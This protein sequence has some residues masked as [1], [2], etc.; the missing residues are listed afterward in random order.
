MTKTI[1]S[2][3][4]AGSALAL[5]LA[6]PALA[7]DAP[8]VPAADTQIP[9]EQAVVAGPALWKVADEDTTI[10]L[11]GTVHALPEGTVWFTGPVEDALESSDVLVTEI[12][13]TPDAQARMQKI[14]REI[15]I[16]PEGQTLR[17]MLDDEQR[18]T[19]EAAMAKVNMPPESFDRFEPWYAAMMF[20]M[21]PLLQQGYSAEIGVEKVLEKAAADNAM[22]RQELETLEFQMGVFDNLPPESQVAFM[23]E[24]VEGVDDIKAVLDEMVA[25]WSEGDAEALAALINEG[26]SDPA[27][28]EALL[29]SRNRTWAAW[30]DERMDVPG[31]VFMAVGAGHLAGRQ[32]VQD[33]LAERGIA[34]ERVQ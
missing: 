7:Q 2:L 15:A 5:G 6:G 4:A 27:L 34:S 13:A 18:A 33:L 21:L 10:Y 26:F 12:L 30:I 25:E 28:A 32:S 31:T 1:R 3:L 29:Y 14:L 8:A 19:F 11:F 9:L 20:S 16:L 17:A 23:M 24:A 22:G